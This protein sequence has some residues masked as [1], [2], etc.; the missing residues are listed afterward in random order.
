MADDLNF[1]DVSTG[2]VAELLGPR[3]RVVH[4]PDRFIASCNSWD[5]F[6]E[7]TKQ[8][9]SKAEQGAVFDD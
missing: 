6:W 2:Q 1:D 5:D 9:L 4:P 8:L 7:Q 3:Q